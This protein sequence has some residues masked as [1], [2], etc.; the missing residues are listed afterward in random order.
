M[1]LIF[2]SW[3]PSRFINYSDSVISGFRTI[4]TDY[5]VAHLFIEVEETLRTVDVVERCETRDF[6]I[7]VLWVD[8]ER[9]T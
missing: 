4:V 5:N 6:P 2:E 1:L 7:Y 8:P 9:P 3:W